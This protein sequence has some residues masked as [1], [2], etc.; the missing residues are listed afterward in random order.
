[1]DFYEVGVE[2]YRSAKIAANGLKISRKP[3][4]KHILC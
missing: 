1:M 3:L 2:D 4:Q